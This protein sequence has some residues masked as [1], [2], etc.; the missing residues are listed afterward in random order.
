MVP[1]FRRTARTVSTGRNGKTE[2]RTAYFDARESNLD[3]RSVH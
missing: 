3:L 2:F 1:H